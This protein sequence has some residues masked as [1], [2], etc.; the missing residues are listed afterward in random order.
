MKLG[1]SGL[2][3]GVTL[4]ATLQGCRQDGPAGE[5][6]SQPAAAA[7]PGAKAMQARASQVGAKGARTATSALRVDFN[8]DGKSDLAWIVHQDNDFNFGSLQYTKW[9]MDGV[10]PIETGAIES[11]ATGSKDMLVAI[12]DFDGDGKSDLLM[13]NHDRVN[14]GGVDFHYIK[15][16]TGQTLK[17]GNL[18]GL[19]RGVGDFSGDGKLGLIVS[20]QAP[21]ATSVFDPPY[22]M[23][24]R[25]L[26]ADLLLLNVSANGASVSA[27][28]RLFE[29]ADRD[30]VPNQR[31]AR[32]A[33]FNG[34]GKMDL[35]IEQR[36]L[37]HGFCCSSEVNDGVLPPMQ[38]KFRLMS[39]TQTLGE[40]SYELPG[41]TE[42]L[43]SAD[44]DGDGKADVLLHDPATGE[45]TMWLMDGG[46]RKATRLLLRDKEN[47]Y[48]VKYTPDLDGDGKADLIW[49]NHR[50]R[51][52]AAWL[53][54][55]VYV[56]QSGELLRSDI[57]TVVGFA[58]LDGDGRDDLIWRRDDIGRSVAWRMNGLNKLEAR[59]LLTHGDARVFMP[60][61][62]ATGSCDMHDHAGF[63]RTP[64]TKPW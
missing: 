40:T 33:D 42:V 16:S 47:Q 32:L 60:L 46:Q 31:I 18:D 7:L 34:D 51:A 17:L 8:G 64:C 49:Y 22:V 37:K 1:L 4:C 55:G 44:F 57:Y 36:L 19:V 59:E 12:A 54:D 15:L 30:D 45:Y 26:S 53:M 11:T 9:L 20:D 10:W 27:R 43:A 58:D 23:R 62:G 52:T 13:K 3:V 35:L 5:A 24:P 21:G 6:R 63:W 28:V 29:T 25:D 48:E 56:K 14:N 39:G 41:L 61:R 2:L 38:L 50:T